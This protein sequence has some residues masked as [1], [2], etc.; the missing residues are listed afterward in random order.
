MAT[1]GSLVVS[2]AVDMATFTS[3]LGRAAYKWERFGK[4]AAKVGAAIGTAIA[5]AG[6]ATAVM[7]KQAIDSADAMSKL[8]QQ[9][10]LTTESMSALSYAA[11]M[12]GVSQENFGTA[13]V[14]LSKSMSDTAKGTGT[15]REAFK[16]LGVS[17]KNNDGTLKSSEQLL[18]E[19]A[20]KF[21]G[22][23]DGAEKTAIAVEIFGRSGAQ[24]IPLLNEGSAGIKDLTDEAAKLGIVLDT[25][26]GRAAEQFNDN[27]ARL[28]RV[29]DG[30]VLT[31]TKQLLPSLTAMTDQLVE[32]AKQSG[33]LEAAAK[34]AATGIRILATSAAVV[35]G[36]FKLAGDSIGT[37]VAALLEAGKGNFRIAWE[38]LKSGAEDNANTIASIA[39]FVGNV[40]NEQAAKAAADAPST[41]LKIAAPVIAAAKKGSEAA[42][43]IEDQAA[44]IRNAVAS[45]ITNNDAVSAHEYLL[46]LEELDRMFFDL[47]LS[48]E[49]YDA[50]VAKLARTQQTAGKDGAKAMREQA[51]AWLDMLDPMRE[52][53]R[54]IERVDQ[55][56]AM[57][58]E[59]FTP[60]QI[61]KIKESFNG[62]KEELSAADEFALEA[63]RNIQDALGDNLFNVLD[64][65]FDNIGKSFGNLLK[66]MAAEALAANLAQQ[67]FGDFAKT[68]VVGGL[69]GKGL[70]WLGGLFG[71]GRASGGPVSAGTTYLVGER[72][73]E[74]FTPQTS[75]AIVPNHAMGGITINSVVNAAPGTNP[76]QLKAYLDQRDAQLKA[77]LIDGM[78]RGRYPVAT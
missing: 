42:K 31:I 12:S 49:F 2:L 71:G 53:I 18:G 58:P 59:M 56:A 25:N 51:E 44:R 4:D 76:A 47:G 62:I 13:L 20:D 77:D 6:A 45:L 35:A 16:A 29:K 8:A 9:V 43:E 19:I 10:G 66:R 33:A 63:A 23:K 41:G 67:M 40:W 3:D 21:A 69:F 72:G 15:A 34:V 50:A 74:L 60:E 57:F 70:S 46:T 64:G 26:S 32:G 30:L 55:V 39:E 65:K 38:I 48:A 14:R 73:P 52:F 5:G 17:I 22:Y 27:L 28:G 1:L 68:G 78:R 54:N 36:A 37:V 24:L 7:V 75:G 61:S 11:D